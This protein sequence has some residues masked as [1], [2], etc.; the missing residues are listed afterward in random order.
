M[1]VMTGSTSP[2]TSTELRQRLEVLYLRRAAVD[3]LIR[4]LEQYERCAPARLPRK[5]PATQWIE[6]SI[7][8]VRATPCGV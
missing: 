1:V 8:S 5:G 3:K 7:Q 4:C 6:E 2:Q